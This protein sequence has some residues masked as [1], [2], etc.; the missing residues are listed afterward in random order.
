MKPELFQICPK[1]NP[2]HI[3]KPIL[4]KKYFELV[5][6]SK[7]SLNKACCEVNPSESVIAAVTDVYELLC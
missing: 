5:F 6:L 2:N 1:R 3:F 7:L 4:I